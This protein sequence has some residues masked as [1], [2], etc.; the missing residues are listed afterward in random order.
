M[1]SANYKVT[2]ID[3]DYHYTTYTAWVSATSKNQAIALGAALIGQEKMRRDHLRMPSHDLWPG[4]LLEPEVKLEP[5]DVDEYWRH[6]DEVI[7]SE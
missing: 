4:P 5:V 3:H 1:A 7:V 6:R 2:I